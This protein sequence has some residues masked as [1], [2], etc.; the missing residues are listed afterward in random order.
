MTVKEKI[1]DLLYGGKITQRELCSRIG[2]SRS[3]VSEI[4]GEME[5]DRLIT[6]E[7]VSDRTVIVSLNE[8]N[9]LRIG[10]LRSSEYA[11]VVLA[12]ENMPRHIL[13]NIKVY[14]NSLE[15]LK[16]LIIGGL[17]IVASPVISAF[18]FNLIDENVKPV[19]GIAS[20]GSGM[21]KRNDKGVLGT[22]PLSKMERESRDRKNYK[23]TYFNNIESL[24]RSYSEGKIDAASVWEPYLTKYGGEKKAPEEICCSLITYRNKW[25][26]L[27]KFL[28]E[29]K[30]AVCS[31][32]DQA[33]RKEASLLLSKIIGEDYNLILKSLDSYKFSISIDK[34]D[35]RRQINAMG[36]PE[37]GKIDE[38]LR[39][40]NEISI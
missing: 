38:F 12:L 35:V 15:A 14:D 4:L 11:P 31:M 26:S 7:R 34:E 8:E 19:A 17:D 2:L 22:T 27:E 30:N 29:Y 18:F 9:L 28:E 13:W 20:G 16:D 33:R 32:E 24:I 40:Y 3:R 1:L 37:S 10:I 23:L 25:K 39:R 36:I 5:R 6:R 21:L